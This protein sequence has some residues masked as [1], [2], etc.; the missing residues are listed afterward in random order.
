MTRRSVRYRSGISLL[1]AFLYVL[2]VMVL[3]H[4][5]F[6][7]QLYSADPSNSFIWILMEIGF[8]GLVITLAVMVERQ[9]AHYVELDKDIVKLTTSIGKLSIPLNR[10]DK[11][12]IVSHNPGVALIYRET[13]IPFSAVLVLDSTEL[14]DELCCKTESSS[15][16]FVI[17][18]LSR[19]SFFVRG[20]LLS[21]GAITV[22]LVLLSLY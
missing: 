14:L 13:W 3:S 16:S 5:A 22:F 12:I 19:R 2:F 10:I 7:R 4:Y 20:F 11:V 9:K 8:G 6:F 21:A 15:E 1:E 18:T 17:Q